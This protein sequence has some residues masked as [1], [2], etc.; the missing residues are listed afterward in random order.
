MSRTTDKRRRTS[1]LLVLAMLFASLALVS[2]AQPAQAEQVTVTLE[3]YRMHQMQNPDSDGSQGDYYPTVKIGNGPDQSGGRVEDDDFDPDWKMSQTV[4]IST[5]QFIPISIRITDYD[6]FANGGDDIMDISPINQDDDVNLTYDVLGQ[7]WTGDLPESA[8]W[9]TGDG[10]PNFPETNDGKAAEILFGITTS[11]ISDV[12]GDGIAD[13]V[14]RNGVKR[15]DGSTVW[16]QGMDPCRKTV[17]L[18]ADWMQGASDGHSHEPKAAAKNEVV[19]SFNASPVKPVDPCPYGG[20]ARKDGVDFVFLPGKSIAEAPVMGLDDAFR[21]ARRANFDPYLRPYAHYAIFVHDQEAG[22]SSSGLCCENTWLDKDFIV[23]LGSWR[24]VCVSADSD[25]KLTTAAVDDDQV[26]DKSI[27]VGPDRTCDTTAAAGDAQVI[28]VNGGASDAEVGTVRDQSGSIMHEL[29]HALGL[30]HGGDSG[31]NNKPNY[32]SVMNY[33]FDPAGISTDGAGGSR[34]DYSRS[35]LPKLDE[36]KLSETAGIGG[37]TDF[38]TWWDASG[39]QQWGRGNGS[40]N[41]SGNVDAAGAPI[42]DAGTVDVDINKPDDSGSTDRTLTGFDDWSN[43][44]Y[45]GAAAN[46]NGGGVATGHHGDISFP[47]VL[48]MELARNAFFNP[49]LATTKTVDKPDAEPGEKLSYDVK[50]DNIGT[51][52][53]TAVR[54]VDALPDGTQV[55]RSSSNVAAGHAGHEAFTYTVPCNTVDGTVLT[56]TAT[57]SAK[58]AGDSPE[59]NTANNTGTASTTVHA[60]KLTLTDT[61]PTTVAAGSSMPI[62]LVVSNV[63]S[64]K[65]TDVVLTK[66]L[67][68][69]VYYSPALDTGSGPKPTTVARKADG[70]T[71]LTWQLSSIAGGTST[72]VNFTAR[73]SLLFVG[74]DTLADTASASYSTASGCTFEPATASATTT[75]V[76]VPATQDPLSAGYWKTHEAARTAEFLARIQA[77]DQRFDGIDGSTPDGV[78]SSAEAYAALSAGGNQPEPLRMQ[79]LAVLFDLA[80]RRINAST[81][82]DGR[83]PQ[84]LGISDVRGAVRYGMATLAKPVSRDTAGRYSDATSLLDQI[85][86]NKV[87]QY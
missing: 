54:V 18:Q 48:E 56:N 75:V 78:L 55:T 72:P 60:P 12:D 36:T 1:I 14:E 87:E 76:E 25:D 86:T 24:T 77:T 10:D 64:G 67:P 41:W 20:D 19:A 45:R 65:A 29:G 16:N 38:T 30:G 52:T 46:R 34:L 79:E 57:V 63:G 61:A 32:L 17:M 74:G 42:I 23:S 6:D 69:D 82:I 50:L 58:D 27:V 9:A 73:P 53:A 81:R 28:A 33:S 37:G 15:P 84:R 49:D 2:T 70:T 40:L 59:T 68:A 11:G 44:K 71:V 66:T 47:L 3:F 43:I 51:G 83:L 26:V 13:T 62:D 8:V 21:A 80:S 31:V 4:D 39:N 7:T 22:S 35:A 5:S 85:A